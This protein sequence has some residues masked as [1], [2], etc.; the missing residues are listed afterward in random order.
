MR[1]LVMVTAI[2]GLSSVPNAVQAQFTPNCS[3]NS[4]P[5]VVALDDVFYAVA[6]AAGASLPPLSVLGNDI[7]PTGVSVSITIP[8]LPTFGWR[9]S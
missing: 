1:Q 8:R 3:P 9:T 6:P 2:V 4:Q 5:I 7:I